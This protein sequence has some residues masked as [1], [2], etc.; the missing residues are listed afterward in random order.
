VVNEC[1]V[2]EDP[3]VTACHIPNFGMWN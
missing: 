2:V 1:Q 3:L